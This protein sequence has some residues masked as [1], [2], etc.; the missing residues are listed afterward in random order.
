MCALIFFSALFSLRGLLG[1]PSFYTT[2][3]AV[4]RYRAAVIGGT[5]MRNVGEMWEIK[6]SSL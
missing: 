3:M 4:V 2:E 5:R 6:Y 1:F